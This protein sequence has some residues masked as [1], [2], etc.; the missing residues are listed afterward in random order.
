[1]TDQKT[2][3]KFKNGEK[4]EAVITEIPATRNRRLR[5][6]V[7]IPIGIST[8]ECDQFGDNPTYAWTFPCQSSEEAIL[9][10]VKRIEKLRDEYNYYAEAKE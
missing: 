1:M 4:Y 8:G 9:E 7:Q 5:Y 6:E 2:I 3:L 10:F